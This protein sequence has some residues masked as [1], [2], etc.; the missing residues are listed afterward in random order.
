MESAVTAD[1]DALAGAMLAGGVPRILKG[2][3]LVGATGAATGLSLRVASGRMMHPTASEAGSVFVVPDEAADEKLNASNGKVSGAFTPSQANFVGLDLVRDPDDATTDTVQFLSTLTFTDSPRKVPLARTMFLRIVIST[4]D[5]DSTPGLAP[6]AKVVTD[7]SNNI[8]SITDVR[9]RM[10]RLGTG[11]GVPGPTHV[12]P[13]TQGRQD[14]TGFTESGDKQLGD[15]KSWCDAIMTRVWELGGGE[16]WF[17]TTADRN[18]TLTA[19]GSTFVSTGDFFEFVGGNLHWQGLALLLDNSTATV[20]EVADQ[21]G[22]S[23]GLT[24]LLDGD[25][26]YV[27]VDRTQ[28]RT[29]SGANALVMTRSTLASLGTAASPGARLVVAWR[30]GGSV[31]YRG[32]VVPVGITVGVPAATTGV[33][34]S[35]QLSGTPPVPAAPVAATLNAANQAMVAG[36]TRSGSTFGN[37]RVLVG[38]DATADTG[39][40][41][42]NAAMP[43]G[44][45]FDGAAAGAEVLLFRNNTNRAV[46]PATNVATWQQ[47]SAG[48]LKKVF[49]IQ[50]AGALNVPLRLATPQTPATDEVTLSVTTNGLSSPNRR[51]FLN[52]MWPD[53]T[54]TTLAMSAAS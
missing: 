13:W 30:R 39:V 3:S 45:I 6:V 14:G 20:N 9:T 46:T 26:L 49:Q 37:G 19:T 18:V 48:V 35:V 11:G 40:T 10:F 17:S 29:V 33:I 27:D 41:Y 1:F 8:V 25:C 12:F 16:R 24:D 4:A 44:H 47:N 15:L 50:G 43:G 22:N 31:F 52:V 28:D 2:F 7:A 36:V 42:G 5:P 32:R 38:P 53:G 34:G 21:T 23:A 54:E 51:L